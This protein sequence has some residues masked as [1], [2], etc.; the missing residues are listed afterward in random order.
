MPTNNDPVMFVLYIHPS[1][2]A[3]LK[4]YADER[5]QDVHQFAE[6]VLAAAVT[7]Q[8]LNGGE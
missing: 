2:M 7:P 6:E 5:K 8:P 1:L 4:N 3:Q